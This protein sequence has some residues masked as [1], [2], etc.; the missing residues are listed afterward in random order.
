MFVTDS[1]DISQGS[2]RRGAT[3]WFY[4]IDGDD[5]DEL[6]HYLETFTDGNN[7]G[8]CITDNFRDKLLAG[9][10]EAVKRWGKMLS[11]KGN[12][13][14]GYQFFVDKVNRANPPMYKDKGLEVKASNLCVHPDTLLL[15]RG[16][17]F[18]IGSLENQDVEVWNGEEWSKTV[19][20][21]TGTNQKMMFVEVLKS[22]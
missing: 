5:F 6:V 9:D 19:V 1:M 2:A 4:P 16:G 10:K 22:C 11:C 17:E 14:S 21:K 8:W 3:A 15:T 13:G 12:V 20:V 18:P 7:A